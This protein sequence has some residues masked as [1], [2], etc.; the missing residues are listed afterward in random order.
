MC[1]ILNEFVCVCGFDYFSSLE[2]ICFMTGRLA[3]W[4]LCDCY[5]LFSLSFGTASKN[6]DGDFK[7]VRVCLV[8]KFAHLLHSD[9]LTGARVVDAFKMD[10]LN[11]RFKCCFNNT[12]IR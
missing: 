10:A 9:G 11:A 6:E 5:F 4:F 2:I 8:G 3:N 7:N 1:A 12:K